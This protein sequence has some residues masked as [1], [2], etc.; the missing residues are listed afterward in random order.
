VEQVAKVL[1]RP[2]VVWITL[3]LV[4]EAVDLMQTPTAHLGLVLMVL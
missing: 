1:Q 4:E 2:E 3:D